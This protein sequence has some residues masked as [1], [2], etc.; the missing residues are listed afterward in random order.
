MSETRGIPA[1]LRAQVDERDGFM[2]RFC[3]RGIGERRVIHH[4]HYGGDVVGTGGRR[5]HELNN[6]I[7]LCGS[8]DG[9]CHLKVHADKKVWQPI[10]AALVEAGVQSMTALAL[11]RASGEGI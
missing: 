2:C 11:R 8:W 7:T 6:L 1:E 9:K 3:G 4:I 10:L 5:R